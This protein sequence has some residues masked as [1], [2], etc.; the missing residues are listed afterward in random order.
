[1]QLPETSTV[2]CTNTDVINFGIVSKSPF[3]LH[4]CKDRAS[5]TRRL[6]PPGGFAAPPLLRVCPLLNLESFMAR[7]CSSGD[8]S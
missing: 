2:A 7:A 8:I 6:P 1:M 5:L 4:A 3:P